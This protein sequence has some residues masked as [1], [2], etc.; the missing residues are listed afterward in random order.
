MRSPRTAWSHL[1]NLSTESGGGLSSRAGSGIYTVLAA[2]G[3]II[4]LLAIEHGDFD[5]FTVRDLELLEGFVEPAALALDNARW[6]ARLRT[7]G[8]DEERTRIARDLHDR[9]GQSLA[10]LAF[11]LDRI[12][13]R[14]EAGRARHRPRSHQLRDDVRGVIR[15][16]RDTLYDLRTDVSEEQGLAD[17]LEQFVAPRHGAQPTL[18]IQVE[19]DRDARLPMLQERE[20]WRIAQEALTNVERHSG[21][22]AVRVVWRCDGERRPDRGDRQRRRLRPGPRRPRSTPTA[23]WACASG[24]RAS[25][26]P[27]RS[28]AHPAAAPGSAAPSPR[29][30]SRGDEPRDGAPRCP[31]WPLDA[32]ADAGHRRSCPPPDAAPVPQRPARMFDRRSHRLTTI[33]RPARPESGG[34]R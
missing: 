30:R 4:G 18:K 31:S 15:E 17:M 11:E 20:M 14:D 10:Y 25:A 23:S 33:R 8:A 21:A 16:V 12:V 6:F 22:T 24:P 34:A 2:R 3:S 29:A 1:P 26:P 32:A 13:D 5:H 28:S 7:V 19:A 9:I 27:S